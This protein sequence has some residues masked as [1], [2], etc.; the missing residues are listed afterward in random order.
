[1]GKVSKLNQTYRSIE[2]I[3]IIIF[4]KKK[5]KKLWKYKLLVLRSILLRFVIPDVCIFVLPWTLFS[6][7]RVPKERW[8]RISR[9]TSVYTVPDRKYACSL[10]DLVCKL[11]LIPIIQVSSLPYN[12]KYLRARP[13]TNEQWRTKIIDLKSWSSSQGLLV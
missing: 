5:K 4:L 2:K 6:L 1:M 11:P 7:L 12:E 10:Y 9:P 8:Y 3:H 13:C